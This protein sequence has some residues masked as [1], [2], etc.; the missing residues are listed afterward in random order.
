MNKCKNNLFV[1]GLHFVILTQKE[2][3]QKSHLLMKPATLGALHPR[4][5]IV[6]SLVKDVGIFVVYFPSRCHHHGWKV[7]HETLLTFILYSVIILGWLV[8]GWHRFSTPV[9]RLMSVWASGTS[10]NSTAFW[11]AVSRRKGDGGQTKKGYGREC[12]RYGLTD[13]SE[14]GG[15]ICIAVVYPHISPHS[16][17]SF[18]FCLLISVSIALSLNLWQ[19]SSRSSWGR[20]HMS[21]QR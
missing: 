1:N 9:G 3:V 5:T 15:G 12:R 16:A 7:A 10:R 19:Q 8:V 17:V 13:G 4:A 2:L 21:A 6:Y 14:V 20:W 11:V 18:S